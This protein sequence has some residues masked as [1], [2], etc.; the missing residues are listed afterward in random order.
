M[1]VNK[2]H[3]E[4]TGLNHSTKASA[5][6]SSYARSGCF[7]SASAWSSCRGISFSAISCSSNYSRAQAVKDEIYEQLRFLVHVH[8]GIQIR[9]YL[10][11]CM[12]LVLASRAW[13]GL[14]WPGCGET[15][16]NTKR[17]ELVKRLWSD[18][19]W[20]WILP[21]TG[22]VAHQR[23]QYRL[24]GR[25]RCVHCRGRVQESGCRLCEDYPD[26]LA[27]R[28]RMNVSVAENISHA[29]KGQV[30]R[31]RDGDGVGQST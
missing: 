10:L 27:R 17:L 22:I 4:Y 21:T 1:I 26:T 14:V 13:F 25:I 29:G 2:D 8:L 9:D 30:I 24:Q 31:E 7:S 20:T 19:L 23:C 6:A 11:Y 15:A 3:D 16:R 28:G 18:A 12:I 5:K